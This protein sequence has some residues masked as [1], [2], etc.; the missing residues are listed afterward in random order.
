MVSYQIVRLKVQMMIL[1]NQDENLYLYVCWSEAKKFKLIYPSIIG[2]RKASQSSQLV[3]IF[4]FLQQQNFFESKKHKM[5]YLK[6]DDNSDMIKI[7]Q[8][9]FLM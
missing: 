4:L 1:K 2:R 5:S 3:F 7:K 6:N 9:I 8:N